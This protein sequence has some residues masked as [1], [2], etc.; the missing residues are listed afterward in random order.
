MEKREKNF[1]ILGSFIL[2][3]V[4]IGGS[5]GKAEVNVGILIRL[6]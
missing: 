3:L 4:R 5:D 2:V 6:G 1:L